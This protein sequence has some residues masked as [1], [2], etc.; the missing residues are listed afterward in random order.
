MSLR[1]FFLLFL[2][3]A[4]SA[5]AQVL[6]FKTYTTKEGLIDQKVTSI[7]K[8][9]RGL[10]W[11]GTPFGVNWFDGTRFFQPPIGTVNGQLYVT[12]FYKDLRGNIWVLSFYNGIFHYANGKFTNFLPEPNN[13]I[14]TNNNVFDMVQYDSSR[15]ILATDAN[16]LWFDGKSFS[17][18][19]EKNSSLQKQFTTIARLH[20]GSVLLGGDKGLI[21]YRYAGKQWNLN[22]FLKDHKIYKILTATN[23][24]CIA[25]DKGL[26]S[27]KTIKDLVGQRPLKIYLQG[28]SIVTVVKTNEGDTWIGSDKVYKVGYNETISYTSINGLP[29]TSLPIFYDEQG[30][31]WFGSSKGITRLRNEYYKFYDLRSGPA[32]SMIT[33]LAQ[34]ENNITWMGSY[35]GLAKKIKNEYKVYKTI[36]QQKVGYVAWM[37]RTKKGVLLAG[38]DAGI[39]QIA[40]D[41]LIK[42]ID[43]KTTKIFED[44]QGSLWLGT[45]DGKLYTLINDVVQNI[46]LTGAVTDYIDAIYKDKNQHLWIGYRG[47]GIMKFSLNNFKGQLIKEFSAKTGFP[48]LRIRCSHPDSKGN[49]LFGTR[50]NGVFIFSINN[51]TK[52]SHINFFNGLSSNWV[53]AIEQDDKHN[54][55]FA[56]NKGINVLTNN[57]Y[58]NPDIQNP[59]L[60]N[61]ASDIQANFILAQQDTLWIGSDNGLFQYQPKKETSDTTHPGI[62]LTQLTINGKPDSS[63]Q[64]YSLNNQSLNLP[65]INNIIEFEFAGVNLKEEGLRY[66]YLLQGQDEDWSKSTDRNFVSYS[67]PPGKYIFKVVAINKNGIKSQQPATVSFVIHAPFWRTTW[68]ITLCGLL[69]IT[70]VYFLYR[71][72]LRQIVN[73]EKLRSRISSDLHDDIGS[74]LSS[75]SILSEVAIQEKNHHQSNAMVKEI[76]ENSISLM[77]K[78]DDIIWSVNPNN[79]SLENLMVRIKRFAAHL[80]EARDIDYSIDI[81][82]SIR[83]ISLSM[84]YR[85]HIYLIMKEAINNLIK[86]SGCTKASIEMKIE[87]KIL[88]ICIKDNGKGFDQQNITVG[89]GL[90]NMKS[91][92]DQIQAELEIESVCGVGTKISF[93]SK[94]K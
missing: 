76:R 45:S 41:R 5:S 51:D 10:L 13:K 30:I 26:Y 70:I 19:D 23:E 48:D 46:Q 44:E 4:C 32:H 24:I 84:E 59:D 60:S 89:N 58:E 12:N 20:D 25:T 78:M 17:L 57:N 64:P 94:I 69:A 85:Q 82:D 6:P 9:T 38:T 21:M 3:I 42:K 18:F 33:S 67:L 16:V 2:I 91:R 50:T 11:I 35:D 61:D 40:N 73:L 86:Y 49:I 83:H 87:H 88:K 39:L 34:D 27:Y 63:F 81:D 72:R 36:N 7:I 68:F 54:I 80:F 92:A 47:Y 8:D 74:T 14:S 31:T 1:F 56:T 55:Y 77:E 90:L 93:S 66:S 65:Y 28:H 71:Y 79:D 52:Y 43:L 22:H 53:K 15:Y 37:Y 62:F 29:E 75:I